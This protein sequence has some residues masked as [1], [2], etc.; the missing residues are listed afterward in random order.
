MKVHLNNTRPVNV[1]SL[2]DG[3][4]ECR[5]EEQND[6]RIGIDEM[7]RRGVYS[8]SKIATTVANAKDYQ[9]CSK[10]R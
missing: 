10:S 4:N 7:L 8:F 2:S 1:W 9:N 6:L 5:N 3:E